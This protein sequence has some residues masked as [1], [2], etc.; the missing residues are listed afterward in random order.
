MPSRK[1]KEPR[2]SA[3]RRDSGA[4]PPESFVEDPSPRPTVTPFPI[5]GIGASAGG[6]EAFTE[7]LRALPSD[8][9]MAFVVIQHLDPTHASMLTEILSRATSMLVTE[10]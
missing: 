5:V 6:L 8:T 10:V 2:P 3:P 9:G 1:S 7:I 4:S